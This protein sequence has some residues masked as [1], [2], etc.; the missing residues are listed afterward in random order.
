MKY[1]MRQQFFPPYY[2]C[3]L[4]RKFKQGNNTVHAYYQEFKSYMNHCDIEESEDDTMN[5]FFGGL[6]HDI[7][8]RFSIFI[9][10]LLVCMFVLVPLRDRY[11]RMHWVTTTT[12]ILVHAH[13]R[14]LVPPP[15]HL[16]EQPY[17]GL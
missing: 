5:R 17:L 2:R 7:R 10:A 4:L 13:H 15:L 16:L 3:E 6:N 12:T 11:R 1:I 8:A 9:V 14:R